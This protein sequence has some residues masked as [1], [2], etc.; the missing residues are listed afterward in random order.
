[1]YRRAR[2][3]DSASAIFSEIWDS[4]QGYRSWTC[5]SAHRMCWAVRNV[6]LAVPKGEVRSMIIDER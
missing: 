5:S 1:M 3:H 6:C 4:A 2:V